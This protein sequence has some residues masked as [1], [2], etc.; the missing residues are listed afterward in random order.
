MSDIFV[1]RQAIFSRDGT[2]A[3][4]ELL[5]RSNDVDNDAGDSTPSVMATTTMVRSFVDIGIEQV[6]GGAV[7]YINVTRDMLL[8]RFA[9][10]VD[11][12]NVVLELV[13]DVVLDE[14]TL[15]AVRELH[16]AGYRIALDDYTPENPR[17]DF[18]PH[19]QI[20]KVNV[21]GRTPDE[22]QA[23]VTALRAHEVELVAV[24]VETA[25]LLEQCK[26]AGFDL[27]QGFYFS[28][29]QIIGGK[30]MEPETAT[31]IRLMNLLKAPNTTDARIE[32]AFRSD[33]TLSYKLLKIVNSASVGGRGV[34][35]IQF[36]IRLMGRDAL[37]RW[38]SLLLVTSLSGSNGI[39]MELAKGALT[40]AR[41][42]ELIA[43]HSSSKF[44]PGP[45][46]IVGLFS[47]LDALLRMPMEDV[48]GKVDLAPEMKAALIG[49]SGPLAPVITLVETYERAEFLEVPFAAKAAGVRPSEMLFLYA[50]ALGWAQERLDSA[51]A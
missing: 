17:A 11:P 5:Y 24:R 14:Q 43:E 51:R 3:G 9:D 29:P 44:D 23:I 27:F 48:I 12:F 39:D 26:A 15:E 2:V 4:Y 13:P 38:M 35:S 31:T 45:L 36:A 42:C 7:A 50:Q 10:L 34:Q 40:R 30:R 20:V 19:V 22:I 32:E 1:A 28:R 33:P 18:L 8:D 21:L 37:Y 49:R 46:F 16:A 41:L 25:E 47:R 6:T